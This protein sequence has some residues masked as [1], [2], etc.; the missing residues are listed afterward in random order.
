[1]IES[2]LMSQIDALPQQSVEELEQ[3]AR[4]YARIDEK[5]AAERQ[6][7]LDDL[8]HIDP[9]YAAENLEES[10]RLKAEFLERKKGLNLGECFA[11]SLEEPFFG[12]VHVVKLASTNHS[13]PDASQNMFRET[14]DFLHWLKTAGPLA[15][16]EEAKKDGELI[17]EVMGNDAVNA[18]ISQ[19]LDPSDYADRLKSQRWMEYEFFDDEDGELE[20]QVAIIRRFRPFVKAE[21]D[22]KGE[23]CS[24]MLYKETTFTIRA[25]LL[26]AII[27]LNKLHVLASDYHD[28]PH[29]LKNDKDPI[30]MAAMKQIE[31]WLYTPEGDDSEVQRVR[32]YTAIY[33]AVVP[34]S[35]DRRMMESHDS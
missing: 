13:E 34:Y 33:S 3:Q 28:I 20:H 31:R 29:N 2:N 7:D 25:T 10:V 24:M 18:A 9:T 27:N 32:H 22:L 17:C 15:G 26:K 19:N 16:I 14:N 11:L 6:E 23:T 35:V 12:R 5:L 30:S 21:V 1:M 8:F 4:L